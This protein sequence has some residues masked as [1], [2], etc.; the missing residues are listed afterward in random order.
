MFSY[1]IIGL[2]GVNPKNAYLRIEEYNDSY[3]ATEKLIADY[4][5]WDSIAAIIRTPIY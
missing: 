4:I 3:I 2:I 5:L 1:V